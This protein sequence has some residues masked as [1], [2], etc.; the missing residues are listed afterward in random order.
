MT[1][2]KHS[3]SSVEILF[4][5]A[6]PSCAAQWISF[7]GTIETRKPHDFYGKIDGFGSRFSQPNQSKLN[8][9]WLDQEHTRTIWYTRG[10]LVSYIWFLQYTHRLPLLA[11]ILPEKKNPL[12]HNQDFSSYYRNSPLFHHFCRGP[13]DPSAPRMAYMDYLRRYLLQKWPG[14]VG[15]YTGTMEHMK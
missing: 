6:H 2:P 1:L 9:Q 7:V 10:W 3:Y 14:F 12:P 5:M 4:G 15:K 13:R 11:K 8:H